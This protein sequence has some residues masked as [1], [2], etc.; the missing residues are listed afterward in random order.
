MFAFDNSRGGDKM[1]NVIPG[2]LPREETFLNENELDTDNI[3]LFNGNE[4]S[5]ENFGNEFSKFMQDYTDVL[6]YD[7]EYSGIVKRFAKGYTSKTK[8]PIFII[9][10][11]ITKGVIT[12]K[13][14]KVEFVLDKSNQEYLDYNFGKL[15]RAL[16]TLDYD[17]YE[18]YNLDNLIEILNNLYIGKEICIKPYEYQGFPK[19][20]VVD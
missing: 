8:K 3:S 16:K 15:K 12:P 14:V 18:L 4:N 2:R 10:V 13:E 17:L 11:S 19:Y 9:L 20:N 5:E 1:T 7:V 6:K